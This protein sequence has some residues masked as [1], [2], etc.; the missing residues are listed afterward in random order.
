MLARFQRV[1][2]ACRLCR[3]EN[4]LQAG[5]HTE[6]EN[7]LETGLIALQTF[8]NIWYCLETFW[9]VQLA[10]KLCRKFGGGGLPL[11]GFWKWR[12][13]WGRGWEG[14]MHT[15]E[16]RAPSICILQDWCLVPSLQPNQRRTSRLWP[17]LQR[18]VQ[19]PGALGRSRDQVGLGSRWPRGALHVAEPDAARVSPTRT[20][21]AST[22]ATWTS[23]GSIPLSE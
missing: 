1:Q 22:I 17:G 15:Q 10:C 3:S 21:S 8:Q 2:I 11:P 13:G 16:L 6:F 19:V 5:V 18:R 20:R 14:G 7:V 23:S 9:K 12:W 4:S